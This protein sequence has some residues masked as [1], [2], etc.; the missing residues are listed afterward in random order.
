VP[1]LSPFATVASAAAYDAW[2]E[3]NPGL[4]EAELEAV[5]QLL[6]PVSDAPRDRGADSTPR[7]V[8]IG[9]GT[10]RFAQP[11][12]I[13]FGLEPAA[14]MAARATGRGI[15]VLRGRAEALPLPDRSCDL[16]LMLTL[17]CFLEHPRQALSE[18]RRVLQ[19]HGRLILGL[20]NADSSLGHLCEARRSRSL[21]YRRARLFSADEARSLLQDAGLT[22]ARSRQCLFGNESEPPVRPGCDRG[23]FVVLEV[24]KRG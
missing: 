20:L 15:A 22:L 7:A 4:F 17:L 5:R 8:E 12:R 6:A 16:L 1:G 13:P 18:V 11:L 3:A 14:P 2:F 19:P 10:G 21:F 9:V 23:G 24:L